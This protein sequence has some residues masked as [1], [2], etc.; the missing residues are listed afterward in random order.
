MGFDI[1][2]DSAMEIALGKISEAWGGDAPMGGLDFPSACTL[3]QTKSQDSDFHVE[4]GLVED[5]DE[6]SE[7]PWLADVT[8]T[9]VQGPA[10][11]DSPFQFATGEASPP[12]MFGAALRA[13]GEV[14]AMCGEYGVDATAYNLWFK[15]Q[16][17]IP[18][19][20]SLLGA[21][22]AVRSHGA[23]FWG[24]VGRKLAPAPYA[25]LSASK[26]IRV[27]WHGTNR[28]KF[29]VDKLVDWPRIN[30]LAKLT[31]QA[32]L[33]EDRYAKGRLKRI[34]FN[35]V[36]RE[37]PKCPSGIG[38][39]IERIVPPDKWIERPVALHA[40][41]WVNG[42]RDSKIA[43]L[44]G[45]IN[46]RP[47]IDLGWE[48]E[49][50]SAAIVDY[51]K[52][53]HIGTVPHILALS[54]GEANFDLDDRGPSF[55]VESSPDHPPNVF[56][57]FAAVVKPFISRNYKDLPMA[58]QVRMLAEAVDG[59]NI[60]ERR[61]AISE[62][63]TMF[64]LVIPEDFL[65]RIFRIFCLVLKDKEKAG[66]VVVSVMKSFGAPKS[67]F[68]TRDL[69]SI[70]KRVINSDKC[71][72]WFA[73][74]IARGITR[75]KVE[76][77]QEALISSK[78]KRILSGPYD[79][80]IALEFII[81]HRRNWWSMEYLR[82]A[83]ASPDRKVEYQFKSRMFRVTCIAV[84]DHY[85]IEEIIYDG[86]YRIQME[87]IAGA[88]MRKRKKFG[89]QD[90]VAPSPSGYDARA[91]AQ[92]LD[93]TLEPNIK[94]VFCWDAFMKSVRYLVDDVATILDFVVNDFQAVKGY[95]H[96]DLLSDEELDAEE[97]ALKQVEPTQ[98]MVEEP[99]AVVDLGVVDT[100]M[101]DF[102]FGDGDGFGDDF[103]EP[104]EAQVELYSEL[105]DDLPHLTEQ[106]LLAAME[107]FGKTVTVTRYNSIK[108]VVHRN[109]LLVAAGKEPK[110]FVSEP[111]FGLDITDGW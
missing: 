6:L 63:R 65:L 43:L 62:L 47:A 101:L 60:S 51:I 33:V 92:L 106:E 7:I 111:S 21:V 8:R 109:H 53:H 41:E 10:D 37:F 84:D 96:G 25:S 97:E 83:K 80:D 19:D 98:A 49:I 36:G 64:S 22:P 88:Y 100:G 78:L 72:P 30:A 105:H 108:E 44:R 75:H 77:G 70:S 103:D 99:V 76:H 3:S 35:L 79:G 61:E 55:K 67:V 12:G 34:D 42:F 56:N 110:P 57:A 1:L 81:R 46:A 71:L 40:I 16:W 85:N 104:V 95:V 102:G 89:T 59:G 5:T 87:K 27:V 94:F 20:E 15:A 45:G 9:E 58:W 17:G 38:L 29:G 52:E 68:Q 39:G 14:V 11:T 107:Q 82:R 26:Q 91:Y 28:E 18:A 86:A 50:P 90:P 66:S 74:E 23:A 31:G 4:L 2:S 13:Y 69:R 32:L 48:V 54:M 24:G 93:D 73:E